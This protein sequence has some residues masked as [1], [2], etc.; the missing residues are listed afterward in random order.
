MMQLTSRT[1]TSIAVAVL[2]LWL[3][4]QVAIDA[5][6]D[7]SSFARA[8]SSLLLFEV[9]ADAGVLDKAGARLREAISHAE[10]VLDGWWARHAWTRTFR[11]EERDEM[12]ASLDAAVRRLEAALEARAARIV[13][14][15]AMRAD[16]DYAATLAELAAIDARREALGSKLA[17]DA[18]AAHEQLVA[19]L[20]ARREAFARDIARNREALAGIAERRA[21]ASGDPAALLAVTDAVLPAP[22]R[23]NEG[24]QLAALK[25]SAS[26]ERSSLL[27]GTRLASAAGAAATARTSTEA[28]AIL[29]ALESDADLRRTLEP[30]LEARVRETS[31]TIRGRVAALAGWESSV[32]AVDRALGAGEPAAAARALGRLAPCDERTR[33]IASS[34]RSAFPAR[35]T[36]SAVQGAI[37]AV[38]RNDAAA[39][40]R[41]A[42][43]TDPAF[44]RGA[45]FT[46]GEQAQALRPNRQ[47]VRRIDQA[48]YEQFR[49]RPCPETA[50]RYL[51]GWPSVPRAMA[52]T[53]RAWRDRARNGGTDIVLVGARWQSTGANSVRG[54]LEDRPDATVTLRAD[55]GELVTRFE[56]I[57]PGQSILA[58]APTLA[59][60]DAP[61]SDLS[62]AASVR[63]DLRDA[64]AADPNPTGSFAQSIACWRAERV[65]ELPVLDPLWGSRP[66]ALLLR[67]VVPGAPP[68]APYVRR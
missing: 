64:M 16:A 62:I 58:D 17:I 49:R 60:N 1:A 46:D 6:M 10:P 15:R 5:L 14:L 24:A 4:S 7:A 2:S 40:Q 28:G 55:G 22:D 3:A 34:V 42:D 68:L 11:R 63:I 54:T 19:A 8:T 32:A 36:E 57:A 65:T 26:A 52:A 66:H 41:I 31:A 23:G 35:F 61:D 30:A 27:A 59:S 18:P 12:R 13:D 45:G 48:L 29:A 33:A 20:S 39:L 51:A 53:V 50:D 9:E 47:V 67:A 43:A 38:G 37:A 44:T 56:D 21:R 25:A